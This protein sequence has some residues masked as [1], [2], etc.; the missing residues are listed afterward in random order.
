[1]N[2]SRADDLN[3]AIN[4]QYPYRSTDIILHFYHLC[5]FFL[6][7]PISFPPKDTDLNSATSFFGGRIRQAATI[8]YNHQITVHVLL[9]YIQT[10]KEFFFSNFLH[11]WTLY[12]SQ[13]NEREWTLSDHVS[14]NTTR[15]QLFLQFCSLFGMWIKLW[16]KH[17]FVVTL[18]YA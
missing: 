2:T 17:T 18:R 7:I 6:I 8:V 14:K 15:K 3:C 9:I 4:L 12:K 5:A 13:R 10:C 1:M 16:Y 11:G